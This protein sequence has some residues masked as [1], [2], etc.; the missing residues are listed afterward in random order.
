VPIY[1][2]RCASCGERF[3]ELTR[4]DETPSCPGCGGAHVERL[5]S[6]VSTP[7]IGLRG[8]D[9]RRSEARRRAQRERASEARRRNEG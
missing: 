7:R 5:I 8:G 6:P 9:A 1:E 3:D 2:F 4:V